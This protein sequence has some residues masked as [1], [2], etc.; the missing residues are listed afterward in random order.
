MF[1]TLGAACAPSL[2]AMDFPA[3]PITIIVTF[4]PGG[5]TDLLARK[6]G[7]ALQQDLGQPV[8]VENRPG[9]SGNIG[10]RAVAESRPDGYTLLMVNSSF[11]INPGV[12]HHLDFSPERDFTAV[13]NVAFVP[14]VIV[15]AA[16]SP[17]SSLSQALRLGL[18]QDPM[19]YA[20]C[21][22]GTPQHLAAELL[23]ARAKASLQQVPYKGCGPALT[24]VLS[25]H[26][27]LGVITASSA[28]PFIRSGKLRALAVTAAQRSP[29]LPDVPTVAELGWPGYELDQWHGLLAPAGTPP[30]I[31]A[32]LNHALT[33]IM[34]RPAMQAELKELGFNPVASSPADFDRLVHDDI[35]RFGALTA[36]MGLRVD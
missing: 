21:G 17:L 2:A 23:R 34:M 4:P 15:T 6:L 16:N 28:A 8:V 10:A 35:C 14:S 18:P 32:R 26:V 33:T 24:D 5:G 12:F 13:I 30:Q 29:L 31:I 11:A 3:R 1:L 22:N 19:P 20:S 9:A 7:A 27:S 25:G 36:N